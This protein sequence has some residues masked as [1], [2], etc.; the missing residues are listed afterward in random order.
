MDSDL[1]VT[2]LVQGYPHVGGAE[3]QIQAVTPHL[4]QRGVHV[5]VVTRRHAGQGLVA[6]V[7]GTRVRR[8]PMPPGRTARSLT[9]Q[10]GAGVLLAGDRSPARV[11]HA[12]GL[13]SPA[14]AGIAGRRLGMPLIVH[15]QRQGEARHLLDDG[16]LGRRRFA[17]LRRRADAFAVLSQEIDDEL[18]ELGV[19]D[20]RRVR[21][22]NGVDT[23]RFR[24]ATPDRVRSLRAQLGVGVDDTVVIYAGRLEPKKRVEDLTAIWPQIAHEH[25]GAAL[26]IVGDGTAAP[27][28]RRDAPAGVR[29]VGVI[30]DVTRWLSVADVFVNPSGNEGMSNALLE[31][32]ATALPVVAT[33]VS[34]NRDIVGRCDPHALVAPG[35][36]RALAAALRHALGDAAYRDRVGRELRS[37]MISRFS[38]ETRADALRRLYERVVTH[39]GAR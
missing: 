15:V 25:P 3:R 12:Y 10:L 29:F 32:C 16:R 24:P 4:R 37:R 20:A 23:G 18:D 13:R 9:Y 21:I 35:D 6:V 33:T 5:D 19:P 39:A 2:M 17:W 14:S 1:S 8:V 7:D 28:L 31:A 11:V 30:D 22:P 38:L 36:R 27:R 34:G 26:V